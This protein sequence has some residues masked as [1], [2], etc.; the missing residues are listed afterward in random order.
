MFLLVLASLESQLQESSQIHLAENQ[1]DQLVHIFGLQDLGGVSVVLVWATLEA[2]D[3]LFGLW[4]HFGKVFPGNPLF[5]ALV[6][7]VLHIFDVLWV[8]GVLAEV[9]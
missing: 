4:V 1:T 7:S 6:I 9:W 5:L 8:H 2:V 3:R